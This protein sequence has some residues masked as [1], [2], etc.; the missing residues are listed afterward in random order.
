[1]GI[2]GEPCFLT[3]R[4]FAKQLSLDME[5]RHAEGKWLND[6]TA[7]D[8]KVKNGAENGEEGNDFP[9]RAPLPDKDLSICFT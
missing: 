2:S 3:L 8:K 6:K 5:E 4:V 1:M 9:V 7:D